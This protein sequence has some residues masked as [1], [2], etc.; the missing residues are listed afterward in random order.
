MS[1]LS[2]VTPT[3]W[4]DFDTQSLKKRSLLPVGVR[5][6]GKERDRRE[7]KV[8]GLGGTAVEMVMVEGEGMKRVKSDKIF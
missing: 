4:L 1:S 5:Y 2:F 6:R 3:M 8:S 7:I